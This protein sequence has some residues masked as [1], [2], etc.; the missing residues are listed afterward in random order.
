MRRMGRRKRRLLF[1]GAATL[2]GLVLCLAWVTCG[3]GFTT[4]IAPIP[5]ATP[6]APHVPHPA[7]ASRSDV[8]FEVGGVPLSGWLYLPEERSAPF[9]CIVMAHGLGGTKDMVLEAYALRY[10]EA[11]FAALT[12]DYRFFGESGGEPRQLA[13]IPLQLQD[14]E[15][16]VAYA[17]SRPEI[18]PARIAIWATSAGGGYG[19]HV[20]ARDQRIAC[21]VSHV[22]AVD[23][24][25]AGRALLERE[26]VGWVLRMLLHGLRDGLRAG[27]GLPPHRIPLYGEPG[28]SAMIGDMEAYHFIAKVPSTDFVNSVCA[29]VF[30]PHGAEE[31]FQPIEDAGRVRCPVLL[32]VA[33]EDTLAPASGAEKV[34]HVLGDLAVVERFPVGHFDIY[35]GEQFERAVAQQLAFFRKHMMQEQ[36]Q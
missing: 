28:G 33:E 36:V 30:L 13:S 16:A 22:G 20:A 11:G 5:R 34:A 10:V 6:E 12:F 18:D 31:A 9:P 24:E 7:P 25:A 27:F 14:L 1:V 3:P 32:Q 26:G 4:A 2:A 21:V 19:I 35:F 8:T 29:R 17:R 15:A 23:P